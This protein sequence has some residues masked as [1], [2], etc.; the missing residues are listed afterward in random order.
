[1][2]ISKNII[3]NKLELYWLNAAC[4]YCVIPQKICTSPAYVDEIINGSGFNNEIFTF[5]VF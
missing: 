5:F 2:P 4:G 1:M 3:E